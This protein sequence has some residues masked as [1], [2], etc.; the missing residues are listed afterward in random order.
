MNIFFSCKVGLVFTLKMALL[1]HCFCQ[2]SDNL[3][4]LQAVYQH[5]RSELDRIAALHQLSQAYR[6]SSLDS[7]R[8]YALDAVSR[9]KKLNDAKWK[10]KSLFELGQV[11]S[12]MG[13][14]D[15]VILLL[16]EAMAY[17]EQAKDQET[18]GK[19]AS[20]MVNE[21]IKMKNF[22]QGLM[23]AT[24]SIEQLQNS[25]DFSLQGQMYELRGTM[26]RQMGDTANARSN[27]V[28]SL[29]FREKA[30]DPLGIGQSYNHLGIL[31]AQRGMYD[32]GLVY[33]KESLKYNELA[34]DTNGIAFAN[35]N[36][37]NI[38]IRLGKIEE[39]VQYFL[40]TAELLE[41]EKDYN[42]GAKMLNN[43]GA[44]HAKM[45]KPDLAKGYY[46]RALNNQEN[47]SDLTIIM[48]LYL[49]Y[50][51]VLNELGN[52]Q[53]G[54]AQFLNTINL[55]DSLISNLQKGVAMAQQLEQEK[56][57][58]E[59]ENERL[60]SEAIQMELLNRNLIIGILAG[61]FCLFAGLGWYMSRLKVRRKRRALEGKI[62]RMLQEQEQT[63]FE[64]MIVGQE[65][66]YS[67][68][69]KELHDNV[70][71]LL[72]ATNLHFSSLEE[73]LGSQVDSLIE[74][75]STLMKALKEVRFLSKNM[76]AGTFQHLGL[77]ESLQELF[78]IIKAVGTHE[79]DFQTS[80]LDQAEIPSTIAHSLFRCIQEMLSNVI[81]HAEANKIFLSVIFED[82]HLRVY[83]EDNGLGFRN[84]SGLEHQGMGL[85]NITSRIQEL[86]GDLNIDSSPG[87]GTRYEISIPLPSSQS[88]WFSQSN[89]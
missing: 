73:K 67:Q 29:E 84:E 55:K 85:L 83:F 32:Q 26:Y 66:A 43:L 18:K 62:N 50:G 39:S 30:G 2:N 75:K 47:I 7:S 3:D 89:N 17:V 15:T 5:S 79:V 64:A 70:G 34:G 82:N 57:Q 41:S 46:E 49:G 65:R 4:S 74:A 78:D 44:L 71:M 40:K 8:M 24:E 42:E 9:S 22:E 23:L 87:N 13:K 61:I 76:L 72:S 14:S 10:T 48:N 27:F 60:I 81:R 88:E 53:A 6:T 51:A 35:G 59:L 33:F 36:I 63:M 52:F 31:A 11:Y 12:L 20:F 38:F 45:R 58:A 21:F 1:F 56:H 37:G 77:I 80:D 25:D 19:I 69:A 68:I 86:D 28:Q 54:A 16:Q